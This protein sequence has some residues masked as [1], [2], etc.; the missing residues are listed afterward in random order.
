MS[1]PRLVALI[2]ANDWAY[3]TTEDHV[4]V[5]ISADRSPE[6]FRAA[7]SADL[8]LRILNPE[9]DTLETIFLRLTGAT[10][11]E[12]S[13]QRRKQRHGDER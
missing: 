3:D 7:E 1:L 2:E 8:T 4:T 11:A 10:D 5:E 12:L 9:S 6:L 13:E